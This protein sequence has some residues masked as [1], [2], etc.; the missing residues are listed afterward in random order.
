M[1]A[2]QLRLLKY[3]L[4]RLRATAA[5]LDYVIRY[6]GPDQEIV[7]SGRHFGKAGDCLARFRIKPFTIP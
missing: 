1:T 7:A 3:D 4:Q 5:Y 2:T 6:Y